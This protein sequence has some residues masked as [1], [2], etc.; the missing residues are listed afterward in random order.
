MENRQENRYTALAVI[1]CICLVA[2]NLFETKI[3]PAGP[4]TLTGGFLIF[5]ISYIINDCLTEIY[6]LRRA[7]F[8]ILL[9]FA[10]NAAFVGVAQLVRILPCTDYCAAQPHLDYL[11][12]ADLRITLASMAAFVCGSLTN[13]LVMDRMKR[14]QGV[15]GFG[16]RAVLSSLAGEGVDSLIFF[17]IAFRGIGMKNIAVIMLTQIALKVLYEVIVLPITAAYVRRIRNENNTTL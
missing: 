5:P 15:K 7:R 17:P 11:F 9:S 13:S 12:A 6:G 16:W 10:V 1:S 2:S 3:F 4:L 8:V 14:K